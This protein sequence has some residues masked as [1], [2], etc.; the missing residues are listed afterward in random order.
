MAVLAVGIG[1]AAVER[2]Q[3]RAANEQ[4]ETIVEEPDP[5]AVADQPR[6]HG[7]E[8]LAQGEAA[9][10]GDDGDRLLVV[11]GPAVRQRLEDSALGLDA[12]GDPRVLAADDLVDEAAVGGKIGEVAV[13]ASAARR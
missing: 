6:R 3:R 11:A 1:P 9:Q 7:V 4:L 12:P 13:P 10:R 8:H 2:H 5:Q